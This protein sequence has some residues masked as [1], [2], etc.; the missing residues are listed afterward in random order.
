MASIPMYAVGTVSGNQ[1]RMRRLK[2]DAGETF[3]SGTPVML[4][5]N[6]FLAAWDGTITADELVGIAKE[7]G[8]NLTT[9]G[10]PKTLTFPPTPPNQPSA[11]NIPRGAPLND[12]KCAVEVAADG[13]T[14][15]VGQ[16]GPAQSALQSDVGLQ[17][18]MTID[19]DGQWY[20]DKVKSNPATE[21]VCRIVKLHEFDVPRGVYFVLV[22][23]AIKANFA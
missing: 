7:A 17:Y 20:V 15:F 6:G 14:I 3:L 13:D 5:A 22:G 12:G 8:S 2:E 1:P 9:D 11:V 16:V 19:S 10:V 23:A 18:G 21:T 4:D